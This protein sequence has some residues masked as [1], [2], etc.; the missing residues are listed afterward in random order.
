VAA[1]SGALTLALVG[2]AGLAALRKLERAR[3]ERRVR[4]FVDGLQNRGPRELQETVARLRA[5]PDLARRV[6]PAVVQRARRRATPA[7]P[8]LAA[9]RVAREFVNDDPRVAEALVELRRLPEEYLAA[10]AISALGRVRPPERAA[11]LLARCLEDRPAPAVV[12]TACEQL[13]A[14]GGPGRAAFR[15]CAAGLSAP[16]IGWFAGL[17]LERRPADQQEWLKMLTS[18]PPGAAAGGAGISGKTSS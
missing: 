2:S 8:R 3:V 1:L 11:E 9:I 14:L 17:V 18:E 6:L 7:G 4:E 12:D 16:R 5:N 13:L 15:R 10:E